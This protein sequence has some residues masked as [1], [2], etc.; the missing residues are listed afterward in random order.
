LKCSVSKS[1][2][3]ALFATVFLGEPTLILCLFESHPFGSIPVWN[4]VALELQH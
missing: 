1:K 2:F 3:F 4:R